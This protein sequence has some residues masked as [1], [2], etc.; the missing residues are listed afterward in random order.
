MSV[1]RLALVAGVVVGVVSALAVAGCGAPKEGTGVAS[2]GNGT[3][4]ASASP[5][6]TSSSDPFKFAQCMREHGIDVKDPE[7]GGRIQLRI[8]GGDRNKMEAAQKECGKYMQGGEAK[9]ADDPKF[10]DA[11]LKLA[12]CMR[13]HGVDM[14]DPAPGEGMIKIPKSANMDGKK[15]EAAQKACEEFLPG[16]P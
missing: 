4:A 8:T 10:R 3:S 11:A 7:P 12:Q 14:P 5:S 2:A 13:E 16:A 9:R 1:R 15:F 6:A